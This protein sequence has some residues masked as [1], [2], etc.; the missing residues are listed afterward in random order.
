M[1]PAHASTWIL[2]SGVAGVVERADGHR[3]PAP[4]PANRSTRRL[5]ARQRVS[6]PA[7]GRLGPLPSP[8]GLSAVEGAVSLA[9]H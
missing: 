6:S 5:L 1:P 9:L 2:E 7:A 3:R 4:S 8:S